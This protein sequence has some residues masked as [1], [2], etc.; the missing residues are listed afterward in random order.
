V[1]IFPNGPFVG[2]DLITIIEAQNV[3]YRLKA[4]GIVSLFTGQNVME[5]LEVKAL[6][7]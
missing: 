7:L 6:N 2:T 3:I 4:I 1:F 5:A